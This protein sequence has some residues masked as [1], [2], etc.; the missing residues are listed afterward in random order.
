MKLCTGGKS[1]PLGWETARK[2]LGRV[3]L[4]HSLLKCWASHHTRALQHQSPHPDLTPRGEGKCRVFLP[5]TLG[6]YVVPQQACFPA[7]VT[8]RM[9]QFARHPSDLE[10]VICS[11]GLHCGQGMAHQLSLKGRGSSKLTWAMKRQAADPATISHTL[12]P[13]TVAQ[14]R[15]PVLQRE[16]VMV[17]EEEEE[18]EESLYA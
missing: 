5:S 15:R 7:Q 8:L 14:R 17:Q 13:S 10:P 9:I 6:L 3:L 16:D 11:L 1:R 4:G 12:L 2:L 18:E